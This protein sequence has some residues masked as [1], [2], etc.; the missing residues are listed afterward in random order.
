MRVRGYYDHCARYYVQG[1][2]AEGG[3]ITGRLPWSLQVRIADHMHSPWVSR[4]PAFN[5]PNPEERADFVA[6]LAPRLRHHVSGPLELITREGSAAD[7][8]YMVTKGLAV[9]GTAVRLLSA[10]DH[11]G[12]EMILTSG[13]Y[14]TP[15]RSVTFLFTLTLAKADL[16]AV[17]TSGKFEATRK[18]VRK[19]AIRMALRREFLDAV[20]MSKLHRAFLMKM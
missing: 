17:L 13:V 5:A 9:S 18:Q 16:T 12:Y 19:S 2:R 4:I 6:S 7:T 1:Q 15:T 10:N 8:M 20:K 3:V 14:M 11:F